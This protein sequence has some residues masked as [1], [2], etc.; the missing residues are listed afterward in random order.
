MLGLNIDWLGHPVM[1]HLARFRSMCDHS[2][3]FCSLSICGCM[4]FILSDII[5]RSSA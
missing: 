5:V 4:C 2:T 3:N 1:A